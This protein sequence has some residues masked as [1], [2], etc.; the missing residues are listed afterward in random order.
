LFRP[1]QTLQEIAS[2]T[3]SVWFTPLLVLTITAILLV[4]VAGPIKQQVAQSGQTVLPPEFQYLSPEDQ[5]KIQE[6]MAATQGPVFVYV[7]PALSAVAGVWVG[8]LVVGGLLHLSLTLLGG[9][10]ATGSAMNLVAWSSLPF[11]VRD[12]IRSFYLF[13]S[14]RLIA[15][16]GL[17]GFAPA[18]SSM[19]SLY[20]NKILASVDIYLVW[21]IVLLIVGVRVAS[22]L[23][24]TKAI[25]G[26][27][28]AVLL[29]LVLRTLL[30]SFVAR[31][32]GFTV[33]RPFFF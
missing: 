25:T 8:W 20:L 14:H 2:Q 30:I 4:V 15:E 27:A 17:A 26:V 21:Q 28:I 9:R 18:G 23:S 11:A 5:A 19:L 16:P 10:G 13:S 7:F 6:A 1:R 12:I 29:V 24:K 22:G 31:L 3:G 32:A 33:I